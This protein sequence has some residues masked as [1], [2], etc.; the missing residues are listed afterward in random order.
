MISRFARDDPKL[1]RLFDIDKR[2]A[3]EI[4]HTY[5]VKQGIIKG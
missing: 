2:D 3:Q 1:N 5:Q 4:A